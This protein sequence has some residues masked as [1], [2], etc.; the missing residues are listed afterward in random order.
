MALAN[1]KYDEAIVMLR[2]RETGSLVLRVRE[3]KPGRFWKSLGFVFIVGY[4]GGGRGLV[5]Q[6]AGLG[7]GESVGL[8]RK[9]GDEVGKERC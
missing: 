5:N 9:R 8:Q 1:S 7:R 6:L 2:M 4:G 3:K